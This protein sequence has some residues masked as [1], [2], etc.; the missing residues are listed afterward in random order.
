MIISFED[1]F[2]CFQFDNS[3]QKQ[4]IISIFWLEI[5]KKYSIYFRNILVTRNI[6]HLIKIRIMKKTKLQ[7]LSRNVNIIEKSIF[8][9]Q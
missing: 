8:S 3:F 1:D 7:N 6:I 5:D 9:S 2:G 4:F